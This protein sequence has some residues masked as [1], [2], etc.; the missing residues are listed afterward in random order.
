MRTSP[1]PAVHCQGN[2][3]VNAWD[4][5]LLALHKGTPTGSRP[6][7]KSRVHVIGWL[8]Q[9][10]KD[11]PSFLFSLG[12][13][14]L[15]KVTFTVNIRLDEVILHFQYFKHFYKNRV[16]ELSMA[17]KFLLKYVF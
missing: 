14:A 5:L 10:V 13:F 2:L 3:P 16:H 11:V 6:F 8:V 15:Y 9:I 17:C 12:V 1:D 4:G 7:Y